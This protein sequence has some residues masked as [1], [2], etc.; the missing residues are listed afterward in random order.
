MLPVRSFDKAP[1][2]PF[3]AFAPE[4]H[5]VFRAGKD[6][7]AGLKHLRWSFWEILLG[8]APFSLGFVSGGFDKFAELRVGDF[9]DIDVESTDCHF[10]DRALLR[11]VGKVLLFGS[12]AGVGGA[13][14]PDHALRSL[15][16]FGWKEGHG[17]AE[18][19]KSF[20]EAWFLKG[21][22]LITD[23]AIT[24]FRPC[25]DLHEGMVK[26]IVG[27]TLDDQ[28]AVENFVSERSPS[29]YAEK[30]ASDHLVGGHV[31]Q[32]GPGNKE[33]AREALSAWRGGLQIGGGINVDNA[34]EWLEA[35]ASAVIVT[36]WFFDHE[37]AFQEDRARELAELVGKERVVIDLSCRA[38][39]NEWKVAM[40]RW[41]TVTQMEISLETLERLSHFGSEFL[42]HAADVEGKCEGVDVDLVSLL[43]QWDGC[44]V[45]YAGGVRGL[46]DLALIEKA[47]GGRLDAT[48][49]SALDLFG[50]SGVTY[51]EL[52]AWNAR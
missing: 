42:I 24:K 38:V 2:L 22:T 47:S 49:G 44:P 8:E 32:L 18:S 13:A 28:G 34:E 52:L 20:H 37:G 6:Q 12:A 51:D 19:Q 39:G 5:A 40:N 29:W 50:G 30:F 36:S 45:T 26:Q 7:R 1:P 25:I 9:M 15:E 4:F 48:V 46:G 31:I 43:G 10:V 35:G 23:M 21:D 17:G 33:A 11:V 16:I 14:D 3:R 27:G 41:Q